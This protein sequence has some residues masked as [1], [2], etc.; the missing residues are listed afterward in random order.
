MIQAKRE[1]TINNCGRCCGFTLSGVSAREIGRTLGVARSTIQDNL[2]RAKKAELAWPL[3]PY[4]GRCS[5]T[6]Q[7]SQKPATHII[8]RRTEPDWK[9]LAQ[10]IMRPGVNLMVSKG[11]SRRPSRRLW[12]RWLCG[13]CSGSSKSGCRR[14]CASIT[15]RE[16]SSSSVLRQE[17][18]R[19]S[20][21]RP[22][23]CGPPNHQRAGTSTT[24]MPRRPHAEPTRWIGAHV[25]CPCSRWRTGAAACRTILKSGVPKRPRFY[26]P[27]INRSYG[28]MAA[29]LATS[30]FSQGTA[31]EASE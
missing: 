3:T 12:L 28:A 1:L 29:R 27:D 14:S 25:T 9:A 21:L 30:A 13:T 4:S 24:H 2:D 5:G 8:S 26:D 20:T 10:E 18:P 19:S 17:D 7:L 22:A 11:C 16:T 23:R 6:R 31:A 15:R